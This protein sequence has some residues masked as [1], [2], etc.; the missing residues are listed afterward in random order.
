[1][2]NLG[3][4]TKATYDY[5]TKDIKAPQKTLPE[6]IT[7]KVKT[8][9]K[10]TTLESYTTNLDTTNLE[11]SF[12]K[13]KIDNESYKSNDIPIVSIPL[14]DTSPPLPPTVVKPPQTTKLIEIPKTETVVSIPV[15]KRKKSIRK[16]KKRNKISRKSNS[17]SSPK[18]ISRGNCRNPWNGNCINMNTEVIIYYKNMMLPICR[19]CWTEIVGKNITW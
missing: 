4:I 7:T 16:K 8:F 12:P 2:L 9:K 15:K 14:K 3:K 5:L 18:T 10:L 1:M 13:R 19:D 11:I 17:K 6:E